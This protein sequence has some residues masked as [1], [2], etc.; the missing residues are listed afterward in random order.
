MLKYLLVDEY[1]SHVGEFSTETPHWSV[2]MEIAL[3]DGRSFAIVA[4]VP[5]PSPN[6]EFAATWTVEPA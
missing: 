2:G 5:N 6:A 4:I 3:S 1:W